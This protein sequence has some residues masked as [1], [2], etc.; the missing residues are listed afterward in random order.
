MQVDTRHEEVGPETWQEKVIET[1][2][3]G[4][5]KKGNQTKNKRPSNGQ[6]YKKKREK[7]IRRNNKYMRNIREQITHRDQRR[8]ERDL[9]EERQRM[10]EIPRMERMEMGGKNEDIDENNRGKVCHIEK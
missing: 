9:S 8:E 3:I 5:R 2:W 4:Y 1:T 6:Y 7:K 10:S